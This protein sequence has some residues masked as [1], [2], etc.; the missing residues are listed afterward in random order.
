LAQEL[1]GLPDLPICIQAIPSPICIQVILTT[2][3]A[4]ARMAVL[5][6]LALCFEPAHAGRKLG[7]RSAVQQS[8]QQQLSIEADSEDSQD[9][10]GLEQEGDDPASFAESNTSATQLNM[11]VVYTK[12]WECVHS[13]L[14]INCNPNQA[15]RRKARDKINRSV[16]NLQ[17]AFKNSKIGA[18]IKV[19]RIQRMGGFTERRVVDDMNM[20]N[21]CE[22]T[23]LCDLRDQ[24]KAHITVA[25]I[26]AG[27][28]R[29]NARKGPDRRFRSAAM[30][31]G[32]TDWT[33]AHEVGHLFGCR[34]GRQAEADAGSNSACTD[35]QTWYGYRSSDSKWRD[36]MAYECQ[37]V[38]K[39]YD[40]SI[41]KVLTRECALMP[42]YGDPNIRYNEVRTGSATCKCAVQMS[43]A[44]P[45]M[46]LTPTK[47]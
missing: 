13:G 25:F 44:V 43:A 31:R 30:G 17:A 22:I 24:Y 34:E 38:L 2:P 47:R 27:G 35:S 28:T 6:F 7:G 36:I 12:K 45:K 29:G 39:E 33:L 3:M 15:A 37:P 14:N 4:L 5:L 18:T 23:N 10:L 20:M 40:C 41:K 21:R 32:A 46:T 8:H 42:H 26:S 1:Q 9:S 11:M 16:A 19:V